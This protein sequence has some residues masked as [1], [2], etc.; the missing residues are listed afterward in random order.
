MRYI[1]ALLVTRRNPSYLVQ[2]RHAIYYFQM[3]IRAHQQHLFGN[4]KLFR[5]SLRTRNYTV[6][7]SLARKWWVYMNSK[8]MLTT[9]S[10][11]ELRHI[12]EAEEQF[13]HLY[14]LGKT[15]QAKYDDLDKQDGI[16]QNEFLMRL[17]EEDKEA[18][19]HYVEHRNIK[20]NDSNNN[21][22]QDGINALGVTHSLPDLIDMFIEQRR[23]HWNEKVHNKGEQKYRGCLNL[24]TDVVGDIKSNALNLEQIRLF[25][26]AITS[27][28]SNRKK[29]KKYRD[30]SIAELCDIEI[31]ENEKLSMST[32]KDYLSYSACF[33]GWAESFEYVREG[34]AKAVR[35][36]AKGLRNHKR[37]TE[38]RSRFSENDLQ[39]LFH[40][41]E[42]Q[43]GTHKKMGNYWVTLLALFTGAR[44]GELCQLHKNDVKLDDS[45]TWYLDINDLDEKKLKSKAAKRHVPIHKEILDLGFIDF[46]RSRKTIRLFDDLKRDKRND[47]RG[48]SSW[49]STYK[50]RCAVGC[51]KEDGKVFHSFRHTFIDTFKQQNVSDFSIVEE[52]VGHALQGS[53]S[54]V[55]YAKGHTLKNKNEVL[56]QLEYKGVDFSKIKSWKTIARRVEGA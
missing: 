2:S 47:Y 28:P 37:A 44:Q 50:K 26:R 7:L 24:L 14:R 46:M 54:R 39:Q 51:S 52:I 38:E 53:E 48:F 6:A 55:R 21:N 36:E 41:K 27:I 43:Y 5:R 30:K 18:L 16:E 56:Q 40:S 31:M 11:D 20:P 35:N 8:E 34:L 17:S 49:F 23:E 22:K 33:L 13:T 12:D 25:L 19:K 1:G 42:Y 10:L 15:L 4:K 29:N 45:G 32:R 9:E 3:R